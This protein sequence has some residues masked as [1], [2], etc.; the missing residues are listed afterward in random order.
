MRSYFFA[1]LIGSFGGYPAQAEWLHDTED[2][3]FRG[4]VA[5]IAASVEMDGTMVGFRCTSS[6]DIMMIYVTP[7]KPDPAVAAAIASTPA[8]LLVII[9]DLPR[10]DLVAHIEVTQDLERYRLVSTVPGAA[11]ALVSATAKAKRRIA[12]AGQAGGEVIWSKSFD[13]DGS[14][15]AL[16]VLS[17]GCSLP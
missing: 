17:R 2:D 8:K 9:D 14:T 10:Q 7:E 13:V 12:V 3:P 16:S 15:A 5:H 6:A 11:A 4:G 1:V